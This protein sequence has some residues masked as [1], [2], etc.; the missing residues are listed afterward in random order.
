QPRPSSIKHRYAV[1]AIR[2]AMQTHGIGK[3][4][5]W[6]AQRLLA[7]DTNDTTL[8]DADLCVGRTPLI[9][10]RVI[11]QS[12]SNLSE[13]RAKVLTYASRYAR[14][15]YFLQGQTIPLMYELFRSCD[16]EVQQALV[17]YS[18]DAQE[19]PLLATVPSDPV[20]PS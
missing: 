19:L 6:R 17:L 2:L 3:Q 14:L 20:S 18:M 1:N 16:E 8:P 9:A 10:L 15:W 4:A 7:K 12:P 13:E 5:T 11:D